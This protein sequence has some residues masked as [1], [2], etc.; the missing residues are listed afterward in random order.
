MVDSQLIVRHDL[1]PGDLGRVL[2][3]HGVL[4]RQE[5]SWNEGFEA[6]V[7]EGLGRF[8]HAYDARR[9]RLWLATREEQFAG[10][11]AV[12]HAQDRRAQLRWLLVH[13]EYRGRG[14]GRRL[15]E[16]ALA[17]ARAVDYDSLFLWT[18]AGLEAATELYI[19]FGFRQTADETRPLWGGTLTELCY[20]LEL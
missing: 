4:Y 9:D 12:I 5:Q 3:W 2:Y 10:C 8:G 7:A 14:L 20:E 18:V 15:L 1:Q 16:E 13:P 19:S 11:I 6:Y 17:F